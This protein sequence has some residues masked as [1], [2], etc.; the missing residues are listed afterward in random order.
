MVYE[1]L[2]KAETNITEAVYGFT[3]VTTDEADGS[4]YITLGLSLAISVK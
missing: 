1:R 4:F 3:A 2:Q